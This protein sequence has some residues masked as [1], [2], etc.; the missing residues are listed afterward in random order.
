MIFVLCCSDAH[1]HF[2]DDQVV[3][4]DSEIAVRKDGAGRFDV[5]L[6]FLQ[7]NHRYHITLDIDDSLGDDVQPRA[8][9]H[10]HMNVLEA[11]RINSG[12]YV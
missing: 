7:I 1:V 3:A 9:D 10:E 8:A 12:T 6:G 11:T 4:H 5:H 2:P